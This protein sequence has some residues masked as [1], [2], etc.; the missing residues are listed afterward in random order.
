MTPSGKLCV[1]MA[2][3]GKNQML[4][5]NLWDIHQ[6]HYSARYGQGSGLILLDNVDCTGS[7][8]SLLYCKHSGFHV[9]NCGH[10]E[11]VSVKCAG[12]QLQYEVSKLQLAS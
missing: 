11:D 5:V 10:H 8:S 2:G 7:E 1:M 9:E 6:E 4:F 3:V 12:S